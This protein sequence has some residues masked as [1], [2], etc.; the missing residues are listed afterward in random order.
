M[1]RHDGSDA[2][3]TADRFDARTVRTA[4]DERPS[5]D[6]VEA[7][8]AAAGTDVTGLPPLYDAVDPDALDRVFGPRA[9]GTRYPTGTCVSFRYEECRVTA[10]TEG[11]T[12]VPAAEGGSRDVVPT[13]V[14]TW[15][16]GRVFR[17]LLV[18][19]PMGTPGGGAVGGWRRRPGPERFCFSVPP[20]RV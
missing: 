16:N 20:P 12:V 13:F 3:G 4:R 9:D 18:P 10:E 7:V 14:P 2:N 1:N 17:V 5:G 19:A 15:K 6:V 8:A 11:I